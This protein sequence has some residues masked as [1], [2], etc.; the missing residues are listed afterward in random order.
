MIKEVLASAF[1]LFLALFAI[2]LI[3][4][5]QVRN[6]ER[7][8]ARRAIQRYCGKTKAEADKILEEHRQWEQQAFGDLP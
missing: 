3:T 2:V 4:A 5:E 1:G 8:V 7:E 6:H